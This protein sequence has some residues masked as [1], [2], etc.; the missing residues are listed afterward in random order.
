MTGGPHTNGIKI[1]QPRS[2]GHASNGSTHGSNGH[3]SNGHSNGATSSHSNG[4]SGNAHDARPRVL[5]LSYRFPYPLIGGDRI[6]SYYLIQHL[7]QIADV[8]LL[9]LDEAGSATPET[10]PELEA[11]A[12]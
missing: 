11:Y 3:A 4:H 9:A 2:N 1:E 5:F 8:D 7:S 10:V 6:K 12:N